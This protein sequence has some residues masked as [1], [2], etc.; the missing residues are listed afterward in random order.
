MPI[1]TA[2]AIR[3][4]RIALAIPHVST[5]LEVRHWMA[6]EQRRRRMASREQGSGMIAEGDEPVAVYEYCNLH[7]L[8]K[9]EL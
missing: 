3:E 9:A 8:W 7:G 6:V 1:E 2:A 5:N 4:P